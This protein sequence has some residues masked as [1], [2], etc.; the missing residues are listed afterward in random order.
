MHFLAKSTQESSHRGN[1]IGDI[2]VAGRFGKW[3]TVDW[4]IDGNG[5][6]GSFEENLVWLQRLIIPKRRYC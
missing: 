3:E 6:A 1:G 2:V 5:A 4:D